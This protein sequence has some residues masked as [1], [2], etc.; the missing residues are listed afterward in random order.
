MSDLN[1]LAPLLGRTMV[2]VAHP[3]DECITCGGL[4]QKMRN[5]V[6]VFAT[7]GAPGDPYFWAKYG[8]RSAYAALRH[9]EANNALAQVGVTQ[10]EFLANYATR[11]DSFIDQQLF[12]VIP[13]ARDVLRG[14]VKRHRPEAIL[15]L[16]YEGGHPDHDA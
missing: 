8:S 16:A 11:P 4:L 7:D 6:V 15:T 2:L 10:I 12:R 13:A 5:P 3:D 1:T 9:Q 14:T